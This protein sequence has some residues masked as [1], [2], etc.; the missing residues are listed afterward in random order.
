MTQLKICTKTQQPCNKTCKINGTNSYIDQ[1]PQQL[2][3]L[4]PIRFQG[5]TWFQ[6]KSIQEIFDIFEKSIRSDTN[7]MIVGGNT[8]QGKKIL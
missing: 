8:A 5:A 7:Y 6:V 1:N 3:E 4:T 2:D